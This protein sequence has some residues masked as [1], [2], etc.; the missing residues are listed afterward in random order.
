[1]WAEA[2]FGGALFTGA[3][4]ALVYAEGESVAFVAAVGLLV[5]YALCLDSIAVYVWLKLIVFCL[6]P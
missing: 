5:V 3:F 4:A 1:V 6:Q 2:G